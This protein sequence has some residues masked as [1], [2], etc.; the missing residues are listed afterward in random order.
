MGHIFVSY[1]R[2]DFE[3]VDGMVGKLENAGMKVWIDREDIKAGRTWRA[4]I[5]EAIDTCDAFVLMLSSHSAVS[6]NVR[7]EIDLAQDSGRTVFILRLDSV[8]KLPAEMRYQLVGLQYIDLQQLGIEAAVNQ[9]INTLKEHLTT[10]KPNGGKPVRQA[11]L[12]IQ[13]VD[14]KAFDTEKQE[15]LVDFISELTATPESQL[16]IEKVTAG[17]IHVF[18]EMPAMAAFELKTRALNRDQHFKRLGI[19]SLRLVGDKKYINISLG[20]LTA[21][22]TLGALKILWMSI[23]SLFPSVV[24][25]TAGKVIVITAAIVATTA[26]GVAVP[27]LVNSPVPTQTVPPTFPIGTATAPTQTPVPEGTATATPT[28]IS[29]SQITPTL[30]AYGPDQENFPDGINPLTGQPVPDASLLKL[31]ALLVSISNFPANGRPQAGLSFA[32]YVFEFSITNGETRFLAA[33]YGEFPYSEGPLVGDCEVHTEPFRKTATILG[34]QV[35]LDANQ[36]G[37][38]DIDESGIGGVCVNLYDA[39]G[40]FVQKTTTDTNGYYGFNVQPGTYTIEF[41]GPPEFEITEQDRVEDNNDDSDAD[42]ATGRTEAINVSSDDLSWDAGLILLS[43]SSTLPSSEVGPVRSSRLIYADIGG[44]FQN[45]C[46]IDGGASPEIRERVP[47]CAKAGSVDNGSAMLSFERMKKI[48]ED[49]AHKHSSNFNYTGN[50]Y[51]DEPPAGGV[52][53]S[54]LDEFWNILNQPKWMY[55]A[56]SQSWWRYVDDAKQQT[57]GI[58][59]PDTDRLNGRQLH[60]ENVIVLFAEHTSVS[61]T[62][63]DIHLEQGLRGKAFLFRDGQKYDIQ[64]STVSDEYEKQTGLR[65]PIRF[66]NPDGSPAALRPGHTWVIVVTPYSPLA[67]ISP[68]V[69]KL[70]FSPP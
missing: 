28:Q 39:G 21:T 10:R 13:G 11:E 69:W 38:H 1:S 22:A 61:P 43:Q 35:W 18:V 65:R 48:A 57:V 37:V 62:I 7:K 17:S 4:Q 30:V 54:E 24:G 55:D 46:L 50:L 14:P 15:R 64:W 31:P 2:H 58:L 53:A 6:D 9:L 56:L 70:I 68:S 42:Q 59:H 12:V 36:N 20:I 8:E 41:V 45:S 23:P 66:Q 26:V 63:L 60:F 16:Q 34:N 49:N 44:F 51:T 32:P 33:F 25:V 67:E 52:P 27:R 40:A 5:V 29:A 3:R 47:P 19:Q